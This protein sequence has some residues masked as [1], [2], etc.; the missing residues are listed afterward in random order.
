MPPAAA[1]P[2]PSTPAPHRFQR[3]QVRAGVA[4]FFASIPTLLGGLLAIAFI[5][6]W[7][8]RDSIGNGAAAAQVRVVVC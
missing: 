8:Q 4:S 5:A 2:S 3:L 6:A 1:I 7:L